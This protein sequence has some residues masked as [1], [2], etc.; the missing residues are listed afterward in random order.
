[1]EGQ[2][3][4]WR[5]SFSAIEKEIVKHADGTYSSSQGQ[6]CRKDVLRLLKDDLAM[7]YE[8]NQQSEKIVCSY[9]MKSIV[10]RLWEEERSWAITDLL[11]RY[12]N[13]L[14]TTVSC[15]FNQN[16]QH[17]FIE[18]E[19]LL[20]EKEMSAKELNRIER[21]FESLLKRYRV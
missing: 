14:Q 12:V 6:T 5:L 20:D 11:P 2:C 19:N 17:F 3:R 21:Y 8:N 7:F 18:N 15:L 4:W 9:F 13:A 1:M 16:I 10:L